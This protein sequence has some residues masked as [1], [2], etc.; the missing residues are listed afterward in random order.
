M[1]RLI[2]FLLIAAVTVLSLTAC[3]GDGTEQESFS[4]DIGIGSEQESFGDD[5][6]GEVWNGLYTQTDSAYIGWNFMEI[7]D[8]NKDGFKFEIYNDEAEILKGSAEFRTDD[9]SKADYLGVT[10]TTVPDTI[11]ITVSGSDYGTGDGTYA[12]YE[13]GDIDE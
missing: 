3:N 7:S 8:F 10:F 11:E 2:I 13:D 5:V 12:R 4:S 9:L 1:K 6:G